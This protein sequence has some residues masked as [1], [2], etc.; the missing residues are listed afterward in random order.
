[1]AAPEVRQSIVVDRKKHR[2]EQRSSWWTYLQWGLCVQHERKTFDQ[3]T[4]QMRLE[5]TKQNEEAARHI[6]PGKRWGV[7]L[8]E[9]VN[10]QS[11][12]EDL[13]Q[14]YLRLLA[15]THEP[16]RF[17]RERLLMIA[18]EERL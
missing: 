4:K 6:S 2:A 17:C 5:V 8:K 15:M 9:M 10:L 18:K 12:L 1:M 3:G 11:H 14:Q 16:N 13:Q 7:W